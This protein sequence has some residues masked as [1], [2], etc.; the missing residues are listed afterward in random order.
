[1]RRRNGMRAGGGGAMLL[2]LL[3]NCAPLWAAPELDPA[4]A[5]WLAEHPVI[6]ASGDPA[7][8]PIDAQDAQGRRS[9]ISPQ[10]LE[11]LAH[12]LGVRIEWV[13]VPNWHAALRGARD[14]EIDVLTSVGKLPE[15]Q[16][17]LNFTA[18]YLQFRSVIVVRNDHSYVA[19]LQD[20]SASKIAVVR[21]YAETDTLRRRHPAFHWV[22]TDSLSDALTKVAVG[23]V[24]ATVGNVAVLS[25]YIQALGLGNLRIA[26]ATM[27]ADL[28][29]HFATRQGAPLLA[30][31]LDKALAAQGPDVLQRIQ[32]QWLPL[33]LQRGVDPRQVA[34]Y[35]LLAL[36]AFLILVTLMLFWV[37]V[38]RREVAYRRDSEARIEAAQS[39]LREVTDGIPGA[40]YRLRRGPGGRVDLLFANS[41][42]YALMGLRPERGLPTFER[43]I[44]RLDQVHRRAVMDDLARSERELQPVQRDLM[45]T[46]RDGG[47][48][49]LYTAAAPRRSPLGEV[50]WNGYIVDITERKQLEQALAQTREHI[51]ELAG[52]LPG[53]VYQSCL[54]ADGTIEFLFNHRGYFALLGIVH[55]EPRISHSRILEV[56]HPDD[57]NALREAILRSAETLTQLLIDFRVGDL[58]QP[59]WIHI[60]A[61]PRAGKQPGVIALWNAYALDITERKRLEAD[62][63]TARDAAEA[64]SSAKSR[65]L[66]NMSHEI[67][68]PMNAIIGLTHL[69]LRTEPPS[70]MQA[71]LH[72]I[73]IA[74]H[75][76]LRI[77]NDILDLSK[78]EAGKL[79]LEQVPFRIGDVLEH[80]HTVASIRAEEKGL[81]FRC[82][83]APGT[84]EHFVGDPL[85]LGQVLLNL[86]S[87]AVKFTDHGQVIVSLRQARRDGDVC[88]LECVVADTGIGISA[89]EQARLFQPFSQ[90]DAS[91]TRRYGGTGLGLSISQRIVEMMGG[92]I[93]CDSQPGAGTTFC[94]RVPL[95]MEVPLFSATDSRFA[96][97]EPKPALH[98]SLKPGSLA[99]VRALIVEADEV[100]QQVSSELL[101]DAGAQV[102]LADNGV[103]A[104]CL[105]ESGCF[106]LILMDLQ[107]PQMDGVTTTRALRALGYRVPIL[108]LTASAMAEDR[109][110]CL[111]AGM[112]EYVPKPLDVVRFAAALARALGYDATALLPSVPTQEP[113]ASRPPP[114]VEPPE[115]QELDQM[116]AHLNLQLLNHDAEA[117]DTVAQ[118]ADALEGRLRDDTD[119]ERLHELR[120]KVAG[121]RFAEARD[122]LLE[123]Q[124][125]LDAGQGAQA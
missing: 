47:V 107:M 42:L 2:A 92:E 20:L 75:S 14:G 6:R 91:T 94:V 17:Y 97:A 84:P 27:D 65:F 106:D 100:G 33:K 41:G 95:S 40:V 55:H 82:R 35:L 54:H 32:S 36:L 44:S 37:R 118:L 99:G 59:R 43:L 19:S 39:A 9:G 4:E 30:T 22:E 83:V 78:I 62:L 122:C 64:A 86:A 11:T 72:K 8:A 110:R 26:A 93:D 81:E 89:A 24:A 98:H 96:L 3:L 70:K 101:Q 115:H 66:A 15:R 104:L 68:T 56:V 13:P 87:N 71:Y 21:R 60:E 102:T 76:L 120:Q 123:W 105:V 109:A 125:R 25:Y 16:A 38:L 52:N 29:L 112:N 12:S 63:A 85:R 90:A 117:A 73:E 108:A 28:P 23:E 114:P 121:Y 69:A 53:V 45:V 51:T 1:M 103:E 119:I 58:Q 31:A 61:L 113:M 49:W 116:L 77:I 34:T 124:G 10:L 57:R 18:P 50:T 48:R 79:V 7:W 46:R 88:W 111:E 67:R 74:S 80:L 5:A